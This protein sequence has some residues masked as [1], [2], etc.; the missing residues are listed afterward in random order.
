MIPNILNIEK[1]MP[2]EHCIPDA[3]FRYYIIFFGSY[4]SIVYIFFAWKVGVD[5]RG[6]FQSLF[7]EWFPIWLALVSVLC[8]LTHSVHV[9]AKGDGMQKLYVHLLYLYP[10]LAYCHTKLAIS[11]I[12]VVKKLAGLK[13]RGEIEKIHKV[14]SH[15]ERVAK[16]GSWFYEVGNDYAV[17]SEGMFR[18][19]EIEPMDKVP[20]D[21]IDDFVT[22]ETKPIYNKY[23][24]DHRQ[25]GST[26]PFRWQIKVKS[27]VRKWLEAKHLHKAGQKQMFGSV[28]DVTEAVKQKVE[29]DVMVNQ[30]RIELMKYKTGDQ[31]EKFLNNFNENE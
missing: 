5:L 15:M 11:A 3:W 25:T 24:S 7:T 4:V 2:P 31:V 22:P 8:G 1:W 26:E 6:V 28:K 29:H 19:F 20:L 14:S 30:M 18:I 9:W 10:I 23:T 17:W 12:Q 27:G 16:M 13:S 21:F